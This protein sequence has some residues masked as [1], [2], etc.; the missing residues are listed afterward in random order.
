MLLLLKYNNQD[1]AVNQS[2]ASMIVFI[3]YTFLPPHTTMNQ[4]GMYLVMMMIMLQIAENKHNF[5]NNSAKSDVHLADPSPLNE[6][7]S[8]K[9]HFS[10]VIASLSG[11]S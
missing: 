7:F 2:F 11:L 8:L 9:N 3:T 6:T 5:L 4:A 1:K 10:Q